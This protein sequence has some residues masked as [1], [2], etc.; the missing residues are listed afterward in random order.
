M[1]RV[2]AGF[3]IGRVGLV[4]EECGFIFPSNTQIITL[5]VWLILLQ[6]LRQEQFIGLLP[7][8]KALYEIQIFTRRCE[9]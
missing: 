2:P 5:A 6:V 4:Y 9:R 3:L 1:C 7:G 8:K